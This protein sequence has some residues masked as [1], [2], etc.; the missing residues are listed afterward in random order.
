MEKKTILIAVFSLFLLP[1]TCLGEEG[2]VPAYRLTPSEKESEKNDFVSMEKAKE[3]SASEEYLMDK[4]AQMEY[5]R[6]KGSSFFIGKKPWMK[7]KKKE[8]E[9]KES[10]PSTEMELYLDDKLKEQE[11]RRKGL[12]DEESDGASLGIESLTYGSIEMGEE[13]PEE[14]QTMVEKFWYESEFNS[15]YGL[16]QKKTITSTDSYSKARKFLNPRK[17]ALRKF[18]IIDETRGIFPREKSSLHAL[19]EHERLL[20]RYEE[21]AADPLLILIRDGNLSQYFNDFRS[22]RR[23]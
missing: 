17:S 20:R 16:F 10:K 6:N 15:D 21:Y 5:V 19:Y 3:I 2:D 13:Y 12:L 9:A 7:K 23:K 4:Q 1:L 18:G 22:E 14:L 8:E 11:A